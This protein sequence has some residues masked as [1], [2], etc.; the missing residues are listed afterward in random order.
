MP[1]S[2]KVDSVPKFIQNLPEKKSLLMRK[3]GKLIVYIF[4]EMP[5]DT[6]IT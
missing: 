5:I 2:S 1:K 4:Y 6:H 3:K